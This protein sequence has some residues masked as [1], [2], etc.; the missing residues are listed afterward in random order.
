MNTTEFLEREI[1]RAEISLRHAQRKP[2]T[3]KEELR[4]LRDKIA[5]LEEALTAVQRRCLAEKPMTLE[6][7]R[8]TPHGKIKDKTLQ[9]ICDRA[10]ELAYAYPTAHIDREKWEPCEHCKPNECPPGYCDP[11]TF[12]VAGNTIRY[13]DIDEGTIVE[14]INFCPWCGRPLTDAAWAELERR[15]QE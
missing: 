1:R 6:Q 12:P 15:L 13:Y 8:G 11:H 3:P 2:H 4:G 14:E 7:L 10:N 9:H 5:C